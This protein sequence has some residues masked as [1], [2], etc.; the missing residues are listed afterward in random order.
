MEVLDPVIDVFY[1]VADALY[2]RGA[3]LQLRLVREGSNR[4]YPRQNI[5]RHNADN[6]VGQRTT[7]PIK[8]AHQRQTRSH[9]LENDHELAFRTHRDVEIR[10]DTPR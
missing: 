9:P 3:V 5:A 7:S 8:L 10:T 4:S 1:V 6:G 2:A